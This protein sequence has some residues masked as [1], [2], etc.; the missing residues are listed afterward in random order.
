MIPVMSI[1]YTFIQAERVLIL[2]SWSGST[3]FTCADPES[4]VRGGP[5]LTCFFLF[6]V[7]LFFFLGGGFVFFVLFDEWRKDPDT[8]ISGP[9]S[10][11]Q[12]NVI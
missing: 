7:V 8:T 11:R 9:S 1:A 6:F 12:Q 4:F 2:I 3:L 5:T 10:A